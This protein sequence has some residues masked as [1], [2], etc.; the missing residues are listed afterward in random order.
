M[1]TVWSDGSGSVTEIAAAA[2]ERGYR[3]I[4]ITDHTQGLSIANGLDVKR[5]SE[6]GR[7]IE[8]L[9]R[10][11][12][13]QKID[14]TVLRSAEMNLN[15][16]GEGDMPARALQKLDIVLGCF[17]SSLRKK[18]DQTDRSLAGLRNP[19]IQ[20]RAHPQTRVYNRREGLHADCSRVFGEAA[21]LDKAVEVD[22]YADREDLRV[23]LLK[24]AKKEGCRI[25]LG[26]DAHHP[27]QLAFMELSLAAALKAKIPGERIVS[28]LSV[29]QLK[30][31]A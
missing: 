1:H 12:K 28:F 31:W 25:S 8:A 14:F 19:S 21:I 29:E 2:I 16:A 17:H 15:P 18:E 5:L 11:F 9:N 10:Q 30:V 7:E 24:I 20:I 27:H 13:K 26:T 4:G 6:Q 22:G 3:Y 23:S